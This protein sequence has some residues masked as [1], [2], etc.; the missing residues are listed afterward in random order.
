MKIKIFNTLTRK[1]EIFEPKI[2]KKM[3]EHFVEY[4][5]YLTKKNVRSY[6]SDFRKKSRKPCVPMYYFFRMYIL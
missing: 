4:D 2:L 6:I 3:K 1:K 5:E